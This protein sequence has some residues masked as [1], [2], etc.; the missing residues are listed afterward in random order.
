MFRNLV[1]ALGPFLEKCKLD[2][3]PK[4]QGTSRELK[5]LFNSVNYEKNCCIDTVEGKLSVDQ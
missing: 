3:I 4:K 2:L 5:E 1:C